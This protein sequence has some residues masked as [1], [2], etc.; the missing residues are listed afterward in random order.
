MNPDD[1]TQV[2]NDDATPAMK[3]K[4][5]SKKIQ[6]DNDGE[7]QVSTET[8]VL[9]ER[10]KITGDEPTQLV[11]DE[12]QVLDETPEKN[13]AGK[14]GRPSEEATQV[15][16]DATLA[17]EKAQEGK[18]SKTDDVD[19]DSEQATQVFTDATMA[20]EDM[21]HK[22]KVKKKDVAE[23]LD[24]SSEAA[25]QVFDD[26][27][28]VNGTKRNRGKGSKKA[29]V[30]DDSEPATQVFDKL[31][32]PS[33]IIQNEGKTAKGKAENEE[34]TQMF[35]QGVEVEDDSQNEIIIRAVATLAADENVE[36]DDAY[37]TVTERETS[38]GSEDATQA[39]P[40][41]VPIGDMETQPIPGN[42]SD[43][44]AVGSGETVSLAEPEPT[45]PVTEVV[46]KSKAKGRGRKGAKVKSKVE[47][48]TETATQVFGDA[49][50]LPVTEVEEKPKAR[51]RKAGKGKVDTDTSSEAATQVLPDTETLPIADVEEKPKQKGRGRKS[52]KAETKAS[53]KAPIDTD[54]E[55]ATQVIDTTE[56]LPI[57]EVEEKPK[58]KGR[59]RKAAKSK[60]QEAV[61]NIDSEAATQ[62]LDSTETLPISEDKDEEPK[63]RGRK[64]PAVPD[65]EPE[66]QIYDD[67]KATHTDDEDAIQVLETNN[68][69][70][71][72]SK[73]SARNKKKG[74]VKEVAKA[75][76]S[77]R[78]PAARFEARK[79]NETTEQTAGTRSRGR[80]G[81]QVGVDELSKTETNPKPAAA[82]AKKNAKAEEPVHEEATQAY[83]GEE[84]TQRYGEDEKGKTKE[85]VLN[86]KDDLGRMICFALESVLLGSR[87]K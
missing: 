76:P 1:A 13:Q 59:G 36:T 8:Q 72:P 56:T 81:K 64:R 38:F 23:Q 18:G 37:C 21:Y 14:S 34:V 61:T 4:S 73:R 47:T 45:L 24:D 85:H 5:K 42:V 58:S 86:L 87:A 75:G 9:D 80:R 10:K 19:R 52:A 20:V 3:E 27:A 25:T 46:E 78:Q 74:P 71:K 82:T 69:E 2:F 12:T 49:E 57:V 35:S 44:V 29:K 54:G 83:T 66:T 62:V 63:Q 6:A 50:T 48:D 51:G 53:P 84:A 31:Q 43:T 16:I 28:V 55:A 15:F 65:M 32:E 77:R 30:D 7:T 22:N 79:S 60:T 67:E 41:T 33:D 70:D 39:I 68:V 40:G 26:A 11:P 17:V